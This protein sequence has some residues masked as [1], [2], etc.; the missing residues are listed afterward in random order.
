MAN[1]LNVSMAMAA[2]QAGN[3]S[4]CDQLTAENRIKR[5]KMSG[6]FRRPKA[7]RINSS[8]Y[9]STAETIAHYQDLNTDLEE[10]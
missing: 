2:S 4:Y 5:M 3:S 8:H 1:T 9:P 6:Y 10:F 7:S